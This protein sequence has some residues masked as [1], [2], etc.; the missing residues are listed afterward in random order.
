MFEEMIGKAIVAVRLEG[1]KDKVVFEMADSSKHT[2]TVEGDCCSHSWIEHLEMPN[3]LHG[4]TLLSVEDGG[5]ATPPGTDESKFD[6]LQ[7]Y[8]TRFRTDR[9]DVVLEYRNDSNGYYGG[10]LVQG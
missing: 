3:D 4:A 2:F 6:C 7:V 10:Y 5:V 9:G 1:E 8:E